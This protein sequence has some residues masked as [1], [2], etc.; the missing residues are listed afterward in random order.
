MEVFYA[1]PAGLFR[2]KPAAASRHHIQLRV[3]CLVSPT[4]GRPCRCHSESPAAADSD[5]P[6][7]PLCPRE[8]THHLLSQSATDE[9]FHQH[10]STAESPHH[11]GSIILLLPFPLLFLLTMRM[12]MGRP[13]TTPGEG[14]PLTRAA[15]VSL[16]AR[17]SARVR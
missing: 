10:V 3:T 11:C 15:T 5:S 14:K 17:H 7:D 16:I 2:V 12:R 1:P 8:Q 13:N 4:A 9:P 6:P